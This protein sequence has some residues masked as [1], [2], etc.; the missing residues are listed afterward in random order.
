[1]KKI[2]F[3]HVSHLFLY[4][5]K[6]LVVEPVGMATGRV[7]GEFGQYQTWPAYTLASPNLIRTF[8][9]KPKP[10]QQ[11]SLETLPRPDLN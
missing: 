6:F 5:N 11:E 10:A 8:P 7:W 2:I 1:M 4:L 3:I 9:F